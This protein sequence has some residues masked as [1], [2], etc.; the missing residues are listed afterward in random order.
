MIVL[1]M[2]M[3]DTSESVKVYIYVSSGLTSYY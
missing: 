1:Y 2:F 3:V